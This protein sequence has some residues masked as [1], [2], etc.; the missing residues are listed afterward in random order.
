MVRHKEFDPDVALDRAMEMFWERGY[1]ATSI[2]DLVEGMGIGR[3]SLYDTF[4]D[5]H[6]LFMQS[7][8]RYAGTQDA[9]L[10]ALAD[11][12][13]SGRDG[14][15]D[16]LSVVLGPDAH[17]KGCL[18]ANVATEVAARDS[19]AAQSVEHYMVRTREIM[20]DMVRRGQ[21]DGT[22]TD[23]VKPEALTSMLVNAWLGLRLSV[24]S[25]VDRKRLRK[26]IDEIMSL[27]D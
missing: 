5:K 12:A 2:Q 21:N 17:L 20:L 14:I 4:G 6:Q 25:G 22:I 27:L 3:R 24:R 15:R 19:Q 11:S 7:L 13:R 1:E 18:L 26:D 9:R 8:D 16:L 10:R 23:R